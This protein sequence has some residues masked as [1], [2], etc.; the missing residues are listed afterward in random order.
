M[1]TEKKKSYEVPSDEM[2]DVSLKLAK[3]FA[4]NK[5]ALNRLISKSSLSKYMTADTMIAAF[6][7]VPVVA[8]K[9]KEL[10]AKIENHPAK[11][12]L[13]MSGKDLKFLC[14]TLLLQEGMT[15]A[16]MD[17]DGFKYDPEKNSLEFFFQ[18]KTQPLFFKESR[19]M[20]VFR[21]MGN[22]D[23]QLSYLWK[24]FDPCHV[25]N[26]AQIHKLIEKYS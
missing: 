11:G 18:L 19:A 23:F 13:K 9:H 15:F 21:I 5:G 17:K 16:E 12:V 20:Y 1:W 3:A 4:Q 26:Q 10:N 6:K 24:G 14:G 7:L 8:Q 25:K 2:I 22:M